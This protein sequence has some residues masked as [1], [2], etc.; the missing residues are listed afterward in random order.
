M[1]LIVVEKNRQV[2]QSTCL[3][4]HFGCQF[5]YEEAR[6]SAESLSRMPL[7]NL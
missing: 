5:L 3:F 4:L 6:N 2:D 1:F 7:M